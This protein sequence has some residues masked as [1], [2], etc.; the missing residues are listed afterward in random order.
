[1]ESLDQQVLDAMMR[2]HAQGRR[3]ALVTVA[4]TWG[5]APR[6]PGAWLALCDDGRVQGS[7]SGG[8]IE[9]DLIERMR[10]GTLGAPGQP[11]ELV[12]YGGSREAARRLG[13]PCGGTLGLIV[14]S[15]P[16]LGALRRLQA[17]ILAGGRMRRRVDL[18]RGVVEVLA[19][20]E[21]AP[22][23]PGP[24][25]Q[26]D[27]EVLTTTH[28]PRWRLLMI[29]GGQ[30]SR[31]LA[32][33]AQSL[34]FAVSLCD[35]RPEYHAEW[36]VADAPWLPGMPD[37]VVLAMRPDAHSAV[38]ALTHDP[39]LDDL[40]LIEALR[41]PAFYVGAMGSVA[42]NEGRKARLKEHFELTPAEL[43][44]L[45]GPIGLPI[46]SRT[47]PEIAVSIAAQLVAV[48]LQARNAVAAP[49]VTWPAS[50]TPACQRG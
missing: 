29:G 28:G 43:A 19:V 11:P 22:G 39:K 15:T 49:G 38:V 2:W 9:D 20:L 1:M 32:P 12:T 21:N 36:D 17:G 14:E 16:D 8:C 37:D 44:R 26:W 42:N 6:Q 10:A 27:G 34:G 48:R 25:V 50:R 45:H 7:V 4:Q 13:L 47:P 40:A 5:S 30:T 41:S 24:D 23:Q 33:I 3:F 46:G 18:R 35:P 31:F